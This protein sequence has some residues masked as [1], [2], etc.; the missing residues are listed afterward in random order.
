MISGMFTKID[1]SSLSDFSLGAGVLLNNFEITQP[2]INDADVIMATTGGVNLNITPTIEDFGADVDN[3]PE[4]TAEL[5]YITKYDVSLTTTMLD[6]GDPGNVQTA[7]GAATILESDSYDEIKP[8]TSLIR[9]SSGQQI[10][11]F[12]TI[13][14]VGDLA[15]GRFIAIKLERTLSTG[16]FSL[17]TTKDNKGQTSLTIT[18]YYTVSKADEVP[19]T[20]YVSKIGSDTGG[21]H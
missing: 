8:R 6:V 11:D 17:Q 7:I 10:S 13:W 5:A 21:T 20:V 15:D 12:K 4:N 2:G 9:Q 3:V 18:A 14:W 16:G 1:P 19:A